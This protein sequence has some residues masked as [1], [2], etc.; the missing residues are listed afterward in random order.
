MEGVNFEPINKDPKGP[1][2]IYTTT[3]FYYDH[4]FVSYSA[5]YPNVM[6]TY[7]IDINSIIDVDNID[8]VDNNIDNNLG[9]DNMSDDFDEIP[10]LEKIKIDL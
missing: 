7:N 8:N 9:T 3:G 6:V 2:I 4:S 10:E 5:L 1:R